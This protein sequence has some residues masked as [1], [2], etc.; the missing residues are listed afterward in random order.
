M[1][2]NLESQF[3]TDGNYEASS[4]VDV[5][6][7][8]LNWTEPGR[9]SK[10]MSAQK[11]AMEYIYQT[12]WIVGISQDSGASWTYYK[13][14]KEANPA[15][16]QIGYYYFELPVGE[17]AMEFYKMPAAFVVTDYAVDTWA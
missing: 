9:Y 8:A 5:V 7:L 3:D 14:N 11:T 16:K 2:V 10:I 1:P 15:G 4:D 13:V 17:W 6:K 12:Y